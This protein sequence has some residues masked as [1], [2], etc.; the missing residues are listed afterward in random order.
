LP[1]EI[2]A[3]IVPISAP[4]TAQATNSNNRANI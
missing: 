3:T 2:D 4:C 1:L